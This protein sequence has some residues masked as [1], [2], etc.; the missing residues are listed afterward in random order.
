VY[1]SFDDIKKEYG[2]ISP[3]SIEKAQKVINA[4]VEDYDQYIRGECYGFRLLENGEVVDSCWGF[5]GDFDNAIDNI[6]SY[7]PQDAVY[8]AKNVEYGACKV[9]EPQ[10]DLLARIS[11]GK[12][13]SAAQTVPAPSQ[14][15]NKS[16]DA[17]E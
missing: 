17:L 15:R 6:A 9:A 10:K 11:K 1:V 8:L 13:K 12:E 7:L 5:L 14:E 2:N 3:E 16:A 4:E